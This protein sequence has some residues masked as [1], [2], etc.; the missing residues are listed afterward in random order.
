MHTVWP[1]GNSC[2]DFNREKIMA[3]LVPG[4]VRVVHRVLPVRHDRMIT[5]RFPYRPRALPARIH[6]DTETWPRLTR[7]HEH[8]ISDND[9]RSPLFF[10]P[11]DRFN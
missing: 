9:F 11:V 6:M 4:T 7:P 3:I 2:P 10:G 8:H 5:S 1:Y